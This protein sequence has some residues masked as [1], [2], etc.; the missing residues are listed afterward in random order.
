MTVLSDLIQRPQFMKGMLLAS[1]RRSVFWNSGVIQTDSELTRGIQ[2]KTGTSMDFDYFL[3]LDPNEPNISDDSNTNAPVDGIGTQTSHAVFNYRNRAWGAKNIT[4]NI[5]TTGDPMM[6]IA[7]RIGAYWGTQMDLALMSIVDGIF[8]DNVLNDA[9]DMVNNQSGTPVD[10]NMILDTRQ[11]SGDAGDVYGAMIC[12]SAI[13]TSLKKQGVTDRIYDVNTGAFL[14]E[15]LSGLRLVPNDSVPSNA[16]NYTSYLIGGAAFGY[17]EGTPK[18]AI[19]VEYDALTGNGAGQ[20]ILI[21]R[22]EF[23]IHPYGF[24]FTGTPAS[25]SP[26]NAEF[27]LDTSWDRDVERKR[28]PLASLISAA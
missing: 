9:S 18:R 3:D 23:C 16:G 26:T 1:L 20:E 11:T 17:G 4:A 15:S 14:Y 22:K 2:A 7:E 8:A 5:S 21:N 28:V 27:A 10:I 25:L 13:V 19:E 24:S 6:A 12:H